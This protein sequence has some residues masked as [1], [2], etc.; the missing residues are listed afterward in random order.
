MW[1]RDN[2]DKSVMH[3]PPSVARERGTEGEKDEEER[4]HEREIE[5]ET[6]RG[7]QRERKMGIWIESRVGWYADVHNVI[8]FLYHS[9]YTVSLEMHTGGVIHFKKFRFF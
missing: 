7:G 8:A 5:G 3:R 2:R 4:G 1:D 6:G 9:G